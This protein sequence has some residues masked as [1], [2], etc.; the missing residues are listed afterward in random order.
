MNVINIFG[1]PGCGKS[2][3]AAGIFYKLKLEGYNVEYVS[4]F[5]KELTYGKDFKKL[6]DQL[7]I[8]GEQHHRIY[9]L[10]DQVEI[11]VNDS[12]FV[13]GLAYL[14][15]DINL[16][17][18][19]FK[20]LIVKMFKTYNNLNFF[21]ERNNKQEYSEIGRNQNL[22]EAMQKDKEIKELLTNNY[23]QYINIKNSLNIVDELLIHIRKHLN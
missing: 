13:M 1:G 18:F 9:K 11:I 4:E 19:E 10:R 6:S 16:P 14:S 7:L 20:E 21:I 22:S 5:A 17:E 12:P 8:F 3:T 23:I 15:E 2:T